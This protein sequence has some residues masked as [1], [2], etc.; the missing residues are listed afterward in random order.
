[1]EKL[2]GMGLRSKMLSS[3][4]VLYR[5]VECCVRINSFKSPWFNVNT[6]LKQCC[7][8]SPVLFIFL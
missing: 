7:L 8:L 6:G 3:I 4:N 5:D 1:M 2:S